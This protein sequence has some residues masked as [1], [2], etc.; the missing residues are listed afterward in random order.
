MQV[1]H[2]DTGQIYYRPFSRFR[3]KNPKPVNLSAKVSSYHQMMGGIRGREHLANL[4]R[5]YV[6]LDRVHTCAH[7]IKHKDKA[8]T[9]SFTFTL[10][11]V[12]TG[13]QLMGH[14]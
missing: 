10:P 7:K 9:N 12:L 2:P 4:I 13:I 8:I 11:L 5:L 3:R 14:R 6:V 1:R